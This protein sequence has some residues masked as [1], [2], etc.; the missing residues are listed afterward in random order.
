MARPPRPMTSYSGRHGR[1]PGRAINQN[2]RSKNYG[3][4][5]STEFNARSL[6][7]LTDR[8]T[9]S[10]RGSAFNGA[11]AKAHAEAAYVVQEGMVEELDRKV[12]ANGRLQRP[13]RRLQV[14]L[15]DDRNVNVFTNSFQVGIEAWLNKSPAALYWRRIEEGD[16]KSFRAR[17]LFTDVASDGGYGPITGQGRYYTP[18]ETAGNMRMKQFD[19]KGHQGIL[20]RIRG[21]PALRFSKGGKRALGRFDMY[22]AY[23]RNLRSAGIRIN[24]GTRGG[25][26]PPVD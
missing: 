2:P 16:P 15:M 7:Y 26:F 17:V 21:Y 8:V 13:G 18:G 1:Q 3:S 6:V 4:F 22:S 10:F 24:K 11:L 23:E 20:V 5:I 9:G 12:A 14:A 19:P 25:I